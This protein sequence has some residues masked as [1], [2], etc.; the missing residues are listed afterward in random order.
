MLLLPQLHLQNY[1][2]KPTSPSLRKKVEP[3]P[4]H[5]A[6]ISFTFK[7]GAVSPPSKMAPFPKKQSHFGSTFFLSVTN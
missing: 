7:G 6:E 3:K 4:F 2:Q 1:F 5:G